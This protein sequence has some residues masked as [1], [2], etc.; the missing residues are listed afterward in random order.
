MVHDTNDDGSGTCLSGEM[1]EG[2]AV[3]TDARKGDGAATGDN[4]CS[5][6]DEDEDAE[7]GE[8]DEPDEQRWRWQAARRTTGG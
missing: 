4:S 7:P 3:V 8:P 6:R 2:E 5:E 1:C